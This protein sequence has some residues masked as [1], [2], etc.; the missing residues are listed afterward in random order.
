[1]DDARAGNGGSLGQLRFERRHGVAH[2]IEMREQRDV[3]TGI[4]RDYT[5]LR[6]S[7]DSFGM[8]ADR[9]G[10]NWMVNITGVPAAAQ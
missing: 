1:M 7:R 10:I 8:C 4:E 2:F 9:F 6:R 5:R 3:I